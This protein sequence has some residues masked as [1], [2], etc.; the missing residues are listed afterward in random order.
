M[1]LLDDEDEYI[2][3][4]DD[5]NLEDELQQREIVKKLISITKALVSLIQQSLF[6]DFM[7]KVR[8]TAAVTGLSNDNVR[9]R[10]S[11]ASAKSKRIER[12]KTMKCNLPIFWKIQM[13]KKTEEFID[14]IKINYNETI[15]QEKSKKRVIDGESGAKQ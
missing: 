11:R 15:A 8:E 3:L 6:I 14:N 4:P 9:K 2:D 13:R 7:G 1:L 5:F 12:R 10:P